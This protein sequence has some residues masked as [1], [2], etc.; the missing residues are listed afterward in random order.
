[1]LLKTSCKM[2]LKC[3][4][5]TRAIEEGGRHSYWPY[6]QLSIGWRLS[7][8]AWEGSQICISSNVHFSETTL[9]KASLLSAR[10]P[11]HVETAYGFV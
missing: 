1:M 5:S 11:I 3:T 2:S 4:V 8:Q 9:K 10:L 6:A 7:N